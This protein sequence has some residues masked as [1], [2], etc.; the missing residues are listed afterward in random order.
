MLLYVFLFFS[1][2]FLHISLCAF[3]HIVSFT[4]LF[5][6]NVSPLF[7]LP[8]FLPHTCSHVL[9]IQSLKRP[10]KFGMPT[11]TNSIMFSLNH[12][13]MSSFSKLIL[14]PTFLI[15][16]CYVIMLP[17]AHVETL[18]GL[19]SHFVTISS[20][21]FLSTQSRFCLFSPRANVTYLLSSLLDHVFVMFFLNHLITQLLLHHSFHTTNSISF[22]RPPQLISFSFHPQHL[23]TSS[24]LSLSPSN[25][26]HQSSDLSSSQASPFPLRPPTFMF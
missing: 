16:F 3:F 25:N 10:L 13:L 9:I 24:T 19:P 17:L 4:S 23:R 14:L 8:L 21:L 1:I 22:S 15:L 20:V 5:H 6:H 11:S 2:L 26:I 7:L 12:F 18:H